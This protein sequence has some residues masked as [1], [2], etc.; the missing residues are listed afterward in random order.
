MARW[1]VKSAAFGPWVYTV[2]NDRREIVA[3]LEHY[4]KS[5][6]GNIQWRGKFWEIRE[7]N[8]EYLTTA[9]TLGDK[10][11]PEWR[12]TK[13]DQLHHHY[14]LEHGRISLSLQKESAV[15]ETYNVTAGTKALGQIKQG[16]SARRGFLL[17]REIPEYAELPL[18]FS[19]WLVT[20]VWKKRSQSNW[21]WQIA[22]LTIGLLLLTVKSCA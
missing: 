20:L 22:A 5:G 8:S 21:F 15:G 7:D 18:L 16:G 1:K 11:K 9:W 6:T 13:V 17:A 14:S 10:D 3:V 4:K 2:R 12:L 19:L